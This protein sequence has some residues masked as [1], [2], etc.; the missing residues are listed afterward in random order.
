MSS[1]KGLKVVLA[2]CGVAVVGYAAALV[3]QV[4]LLVRMLH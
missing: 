4:V 1:D 3:A 2:F